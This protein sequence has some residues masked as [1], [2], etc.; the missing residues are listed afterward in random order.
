[1]V[2]DSR[3]KLFKVIDLNETPPK[4]SVQVDSSTVASFNGQSGRII[5]KIDAIV[6]SLNKDGHAISDISCK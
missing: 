6:E 2:Y 3:K 5:N 4:V 1:M